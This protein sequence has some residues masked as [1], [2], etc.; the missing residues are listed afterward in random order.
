MTG[1]PVRALRPGART[2]ER[3]LVEKVDA[4]LVGYA[5]LIAAMAHRL[6]LSEGPVAFE[7]PS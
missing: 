6:G 5:E 1:W 2:Q 4:A 7:N 3:A